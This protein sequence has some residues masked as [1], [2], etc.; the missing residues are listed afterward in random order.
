MTDICEKSRTLGGEPRSGAVLR[1]KVHDGLLG[2]GA[3]L[4]MDTSRVSAIVVDV[5]QEKGR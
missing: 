1:V 2:L 3:L 5:L 4:L